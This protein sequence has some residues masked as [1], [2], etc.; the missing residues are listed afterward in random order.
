[1]EQLTGLKLGKEY[2]KSVYCH[3]TCLTHM[4]STTCE[5]LGWMNHSWNLYCEAKYQQ[6]QICRRYHS[7]G[8]K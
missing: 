7:S 2:G 6:P 4:Q 3:L 1:M 5:I 8:R